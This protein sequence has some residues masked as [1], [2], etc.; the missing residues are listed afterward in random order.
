[1]PVL[2]TLSG[3]IFGVFCVLTGFWCWTGLWRIQE[4]PE[5]RGFFPCLR[6]AEG[7]LLCPLVL[8]ASSGK[9]AHISEP[10]KP[11]HPLEHTDLGWSRLHWASPGAAG[12]R[13]GGF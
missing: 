4:L 5:S 13:T 11:E 9:A 2:A 6:Y 1:M 3:N 7:K 8:F 12:A 10:G